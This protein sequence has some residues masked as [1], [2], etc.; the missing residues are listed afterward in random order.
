MAM[1]YKTSEAT[2]Y[3]K[4]FSN[5]VKEEVK[6]QG[7]N[8][9][10]NKLQHFYIDAV[11]YFDRIDKDPNNYWKCMLDA[12]TDTGLIWVDDNVTC[13]RVQRIYYDSKNP[14]VV[15]EIYPV[16][17]IGVFDNTAQLEEFESNCIG[18]KRYKRNCSILNKAKEGKIQEEIHC[19]QCDKY[20]KI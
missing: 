6:K 1:S 10:P 8:L 16:D 9:K 17:Y 20:N 7:Y 14:R 15:L 19:L 2:K 11:F 4:N 3:Q 5:Y 13:E 18:C 12:I